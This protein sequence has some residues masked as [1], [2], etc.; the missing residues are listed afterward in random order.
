M[1]TPRPTL[2]SDLG[3]IESKAKS[4]LTENAWG[5]YASGS[6][7][8]STLAANATA[9]ELWRLLP[10]VM[11]VHIDSA[12]RYMHMTLCS[13]LQFPSIVT[14]LGLLWSMKTLKQRIAM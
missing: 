3:E 10:R 1:V 11:C 5:Y 2:G 9:F 7:S 12:K 4:I 6:E 14:S 13:H 8:E